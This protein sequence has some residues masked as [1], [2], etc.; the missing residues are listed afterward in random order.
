VLRSSHA[1][2]GVPPTEAMLVMVAF[3]GNAATPGEPIFL[4]RP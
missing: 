1:S 4:T 3:I 2:G